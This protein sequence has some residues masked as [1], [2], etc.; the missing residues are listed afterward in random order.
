MNGEARSIAEAAYCRAF[1]NSLGSNPVYFNYDSGIL[2]FEGVK[3]M[4]AFGNFKR[5]SKIK[6]GVVNRK[7]PLETEA[8]QRIRHIAIRAQSENWI[9]VWVVNRFERL[10]SLLLEHQTP[11]ME[12]HQLPYQF[13]Q[14]KGKKIKC[15]KHYY[16][17]S[18]FEKVMRRLKVSIITS[19]V[20]FKISDIGIG[21]QVCD[22]GWP[23]SISSQ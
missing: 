17:N 3:A 6:C 20:T 14:G 5:P 22:H 8:I 11:S 2:Y 18:S 10:D 7:N 19:G 23:R 12:R 21:L 9:T 13:H 16:D 1:S 4:V 15:G